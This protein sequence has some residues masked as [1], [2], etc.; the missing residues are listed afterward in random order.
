MAKTITCIEA[1]S[2]LQAYLDN[3][4]GGPTEQDIDHH[5]DNCRECFSRSE[6]ETALRKKV[7]QI[8]ATKTPQDIQQRLTSLIKK[9]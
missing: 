4:V 3:E 9:F 2:K 7:V 1:M 8:S 6:F 5:L